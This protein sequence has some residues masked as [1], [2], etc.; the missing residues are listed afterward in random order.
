MRSEIQHHPLLPSAK[1]PRVCQRRH[2]GS[3]LDRSTSCI[4][5]PTPFE[6]PAIDIPCPT[7]DRAV[8]D[9][10]PEEDEDHHGNEATSLGNGTDNDGGCDG[11]ELHL[12][13]H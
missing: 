11:A 6:E 8:Y 5:K 13:I 3:N 10:G 12:E 2:A 1:N 9:C 7:C 4:V